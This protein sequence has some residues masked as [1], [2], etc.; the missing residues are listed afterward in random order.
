M[1]PTTLPISRPRPTDH[2]FHEH[3]RGEQ[4]NGFDR[5]RPL[6][7]AD[8]VDAFEGGERFGS[9]IGAERGA[10]GPLVDES[11]R[12]DRDY[13]SISQLSRFPQVSDMPDVKQV[14]YPVALHDLRTLGCGSTEVLR[15][16]LN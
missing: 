4:T 15:D 14:E 7:N 5:R 16:F 1:L 8:E 9:Q 10:V 12:G 13:E 6:A 2:S 3:V 11:I